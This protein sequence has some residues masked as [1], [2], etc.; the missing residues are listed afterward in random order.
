M[1][2]F[3]WL[4]VDFSLWSNRFVKYCKE[5]FLE[6]AIQ[7]KLQNQMS[8]ST[9]IPSHQASWACLH[10]N[11]ENTILMRIINCMY[12]ILIAIEMHCCFMIFNLAC[13]NIM[14]WRHFVNNKLIIMNILLQKFD[15]QYM[16]IIT[17]SHCNNKIK[18]S[19]QIN[20]S[21]NFVSLLLGF[22]KSKFWPVKQ[23]HCKSLVCQRYLCSTFS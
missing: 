13:M 14:Q 12:S 15:Y 10:V 21:L 17:I 11:V 18:L 7:I 23:E 8:I 9:S 19:L 22:F 4:H 6:L 2:I 5:I 1:Q 3:I 16:Y 20:F